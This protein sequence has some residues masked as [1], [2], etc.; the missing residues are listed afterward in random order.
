MEGVGCSLQPPTYT[1]HPTPYTLHPKRGF[2]LVCVLWVLAILTVITVGFGRRA[3]LD[4]RA[5]AFSLDHTQAMLMARGA[6]ERGIVELRNKAVIDALYKQ[7]GRTSKAQRWANT[8]DMLEEKGYYADP[9]ENLKGE[10][11]RY[12]M[13]DEESL[14]SINAADEKL[15]E[16]IK[17]LTRPAVRKIM[18]R[19]NGD[20]DT[21]E[22]AQAFQA[23]EELRTLE[24][25]KDKN[26]FGTDKAVGLK[27]L[28]TCWGD[29]KININTASRDVL[30]C[31]PDLQENVIDAIIQYREGPDAQLGT[32]DDQEFVSLSEV[33]EKA[34][35]GGQSIE[36]L[37]QYC[38]VD[39]GYF[40]ITGIA[41]RRQG[42]VVAS[43]VATVSIQPPQAWVIKWREDFLDS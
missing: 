3:M 1:L 39:S 41:T 20:R 24:G 36:P 32:A 9:G 12:I 33:T 18:H 16:R 11:C 29:G 27:D 37:Q 26:W 7:S 10:I 15:L 38:K 2:V 42:K 35:L 22:P 43:C 28:L 23:I 40:T 4:R 25:V 6:V 19:R 34:G 30:S 14:I 31:I 13:R 8:M 5:A 21:D 17:S